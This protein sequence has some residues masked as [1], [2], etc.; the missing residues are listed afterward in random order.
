MNTT[1]SKAVSDIIGTA[2]L[3]GVAV[4]VCSVLYNIVLSSP[5]PQ[6]TPNVTLVGTVIGDTITIEHRGGDDL[7]LDT[8]IILRVDQSNQLYQFTVRQGLDSNSLQD[9]KWNV[10]EQ[11]RHSLNNLTSFNYNQNSAQAEITIVD[12][13]SNTMVMAGT[14]DIHPVADVGVTVSVDKP[15]PK[16]SFTHPNYL[17]IMINVTNYRGDL[18]NITGIQIKCKLPDT[19]HYNFHS[20][21]AYDYNNETGIWTIHAPLEKKQSIVLTLNTTITI[22][23]NVMEPAQLVMILDGSGSISSSD[24]SLMREGL[25]RSIEN[26]SNFPHDD[27]VELTVVQFGDVNP[28]YARVEIEPTLVNEA[29]YQQITDHIHN[30][31]QMANPQEGGAT[32]LGCGIRLAADQLR[33][34]GQFD[35]NKRQIVNLVTDGVPN[36][37]WTTGTYKGTYQG[38]DGWFKGDDQHHSGNYSAKSSSSRHGDFTSDDL[39]A[40]GATS[41]TVDFWYRLHSTGSNDLRLYFYDGSSYDS[42]S[43]L[44]GGTKDTWVHYT[45]VITDPQY[46]K[47]NFKIRFTTTGQGTVWI[48]DVL[49][50]TNKNLLNDNFEGD[51]WAEHWWNPGSKSAEEAQSYLVNTLQMTSDKDEFDS[52]GVGVGGMYGGP[53]TDWLKN[54]IV[55]PQPG[56]IAPPYT[57]GWVK[58]ITSWQD[59]ESAISEIFQVQFSFIIGTVSVINLNVE[60]P[61]HSNDLASVTIIPQ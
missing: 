43:S 16:I 60:D 56:H 58:T 45:R 47:N 25:A 54:K 27:S 55:W 11:F 23:E 8:K 10:G 57:T 33:N 3:L 35:V 53:D 41:I 49:I 9:G 24:W 13:S 30:M 26:S 40:T 61:N 42:I 46:F 20:P 17:N 1:S 29:N 48:D 15:N 2:V 38:W 44:G 12:P 32:P 7:S 6:T 21:S 36:C 5:T 18:N 28:P 34:V 39:D 19:L 4:I 52:L 51:Y 50:K 22:N 37:D 59:F 31:T 14:L